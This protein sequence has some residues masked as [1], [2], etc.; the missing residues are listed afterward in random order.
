MSNRIE[1]P[2]PE[3]LER[4]I[5]R[6][7]RHASLVFE[8]AL[9]TWTMV[10]LTSAKPM[11][12]VQKPELTVIYFK[13][14]L[15][16]STPVM[17]EFVG[18]IALTGKGIENKTCTWITEQGERSIGFRTTNE[19]GL[20]WLNLQFARANRMRFREHGIVDPRKV[21]YRRTP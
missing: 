8:L 10:R 20:K 9:P 7:E 12:V 11:P 4:A 1:Q 15:L 5:A 3:E 2:S 6:V 18:N 21:T 14:I 19:D 16:V 13:P 17:P